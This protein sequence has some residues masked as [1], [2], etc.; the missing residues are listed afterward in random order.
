MLSTA[1][2]YYIYIS[3]TKVDMLLPQVPH[4]VKKKVATEFGIDLKLL[5]AK[6]KTEEDSDENR[7]SRLETV[8][9]FILEYGNVGTVDQPDQYIED[10]LPMRWGPYAAIGYGGP[11]F[12]YFGGETDRTIY[13]LGG[14]LH[15][16]IGN[17]GTSEASSAS[18][19]PNL[20]SYL[21]KHLATGESEVKGD[22]IRGAQTSLD[23]ELAG[24]HFATTG[25]RGPQQRLEFL[26]KR[27]LQGPSP[28]P[29]RDR[30]AGVQVL[31]ATPL[32]V[33][34]AD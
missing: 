13:G 10:T 5:T 12:V 27:L 29:E 17:V 16:V 18:A 25:M 26:A 21:G 14:S 22:E 1:M 3:D 23:M 31:L 6:R 11:G 4:D 32:Y 19:T 28:F 8:V 15:H 7:I 24:I 34:M 9:K 30:R 20:L 33:A 2:K